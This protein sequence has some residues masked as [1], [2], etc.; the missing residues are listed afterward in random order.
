MSDYVFSVS[1]FKDT[2][3][4]LTELAEKCIGEDIC[5]HRGA[6]V[7]NACTCNGTQFFGV[8]ATFITKLPV[9]R[10]G[11]KSYQD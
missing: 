2:I 5:K 7:H 3:F 11:K 4:K 1:Y 9:V 6:I 10:D 8:F